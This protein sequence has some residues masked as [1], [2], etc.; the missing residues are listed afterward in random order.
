MK[1]R[2]RDRA[3]ENSALP[4]RGGRLEATSRPKTVPPNL[5]EIYPDGRKTRGFR[6]SKPTDILICGLK[7]ITSD[8]RYLSMVR[9]PTLDHTM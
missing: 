6:P 8:K 4:Y 3:T 5:A 1:A 7:S 2:F 9:R